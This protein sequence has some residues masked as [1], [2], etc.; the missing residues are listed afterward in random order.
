MDATGQSEADV[1]ASN[2]KLADEPAVANSKP[3]AAGSAQNRAVPA[4]MIDPWA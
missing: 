2:P 1:L 3:R 4:G